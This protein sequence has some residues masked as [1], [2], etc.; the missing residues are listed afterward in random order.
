MS[1]DD[2]TNLDGPPGLRFE[3]WESQKKDG[4]IDEALQKEKAVETTR[5]YSNLFTNSIRNKQTETN[6]AKAS[7]DTYIGINGRQWDT[8]SINKLDDQNRVAH[9]FNVTKPNVDK[10]YGQIVKNP[11]EVIYTPIN[12]KDLS[13]SNIVQSLWEY[14][15]ERGSFQREWNKFVKETLIHTGVL[16]MYKDYKHNNILGNIGLKSI[17]RYLDIVFDPYWSTDRIEDCQYIF[18]STW[19]TAREIKD[20]YRAKSEEIDRS[21]NQFE[22]RDGASF[23]VETVEELRER[24]SEYYDSTRDRYR[25]IEVVYMQKVH[26]VRKYSQKLERFLKDNEHPDTMRGENDTLIEHSEYENIC[27]VMTMAPGVQHG[28]ILQEGDHP[29]QIGRLPFFVASSDNTMGER[30]G[31]VTGVIDAQTTLNKRQSMLTGNQVTSSNGGI[32]VKEN[33]FK[34]AAEFNRFVDERNIPGRVF[35]ADDNAKLSDGIINIP[36]NKMPEGL[37]RSIDWAEIYI[38]KYMSNTTAVQGTSGGA[39]ETNVLFES[40]KSQ[41]QIAHV[42]IMEVL[43][44][45]LKDIAEAYFYFSKKIYAGPKRSFTNAR[46]GEQFTINERKPIDNKKFASLE[47]GNT[48]VNNYLAGFETINNIAELPRHDVVIKK[49]KFGLD[50]KQR[51]LLTYDQMIQRSVNPI[52]KAQW[53]KYMIPLMDELPPEAIPQLMA[54]ADVFIEFQ[55]AQLQ[56]NITTMRNNTIQSNVATQSMIQQAGGQP[57]MPAQPNEPDAR[58][59]GNASGQGNL[60]QPLAQDQSSANNQAQS[61]FNN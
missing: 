24:D 58:S 21:I 29:V 16:E 12:N 42:G 4:D 3:H 49:S 61:D 2:V 54:S 11:S 15:F 43:D 6:N 50:Q 37:E 46:T 39:N 41:A 17:N 9:T 45:C 56:T 55:T 8:K 1:K 36:M 47:I 44:Q 23:D 28:L 31:V 53:E 26:K 14:D 51:A 52:M 22:R 60:I 20:E 18:K 33:F 57:E 32:I 48:S 10:V 40:K 25:V 59:A 34:N 27:K 5:Y 13:G 30:Q 35:K 19:K 38:E 7:F